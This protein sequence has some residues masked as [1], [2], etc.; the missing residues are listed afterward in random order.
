[1]TVENLPHWSILPNWR[2]PITERLE[3]QSAVL[4]G[5]AGAEQRL[6]LRWSPRRSFEALITPVG[7]VRT[8]FDLAVGRVGVDPW[9]LPVWHD[10]TF[11][12]APLA[13]DETVLPIDTTDRE[14]AAGGFVMLWQDEFTTEVL[15]IASVGPS[16][17]TFVA[18]PARTWPAGSR[19]FPAVKARLYQQ[20]EMAR[21]AGR[22]ME[23]ALRF[24]VVGS[25]DVTAATLSPTYLTFPVLT[26]GPNE[27]ADITHAYVRLFDELD[28][29][30]GIPER[31]HT[32][33]VGFTMQR[34]TWWGV[35]RAEHAALRAYFY[36]LEGKVNP[37]W[38]PTFAE[39][40]YVLDP[41]TAAAA[42]LRVAKCGFTAY[43]GPREGRQ[44]I[45]IALK[46]GTFIHRRITGST[47]NLDG[48]EN[49]VLAS[50]V[51]QNIALA[52][53]ER[54]SFM[55]LSRLDTDNIEIVHHTDNQGLC[56]VSATFRSAPDIRVDTDWTPPPFLNTTQVPGA[57][58]D[59]VPGFTLISETKVA[60]Q[61]DGP[62]FLGGVNIYDQGDLFSLAGGAYA[63]TYMLGTDVIVRRVSGSDVV[64]SRT[65][66]IGVS[67]LTSATPF[68]FHG[69][70]L[71]DGRYVT[72]T[73]ETFTGTFGL[74]S[75]VS[76][77]TFDATGALVEG[78]VLIAGSGV[79]PDGG[80]CY[81]VTAGD[82]GTYYAALL[83]RE[84]G[85]DRVRIRKFDAEHAELDSTPNEVWAT[86]GTYETIR[87]NSLV[88]FGDTLAL[89][90]STDYPTGRTQR[91][92]LHFYGT[93]LAEIAVY[94]EVNDLSPPVGGYDKL[95]GIFAASDGRL[96]VVWQYL[97]NG[98]WDYGGVSQL[99]VRFFNQDGTPDGASALLHTYTD[100]DGFNDPDRY[101]YG[102]AISPSGTIVLEGEAMTYDGSNYASAP[103][104]WAY[105]FNGS[106]WS[107]TAS[108]SL[109]GAPSAGFWTWGGNVRRL[110]NGDWIALAYRNDGDLRAARLALTECP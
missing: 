53:I 21:R 34:H 76:A 54:V 35:G 7:P 78:P 50:A 49:I 107:E 38:L 42:S 1:M 24:E 17:I 72:L 6:G 57:C 15:E 84:G 74:G 109:W 19:I 2:S 96:G 26:T 61:Y 86:Y 94:V 77:R 100:I 14:F 11:L 23:N 95:V 45:Q 30:V 18:G 62:T 106:T 97:E 5:A 40:L 81:G 16:S 64:G 101:F 90:H 47:L 80:T 68:A 10:V 73:S 89:A 103:Y 65:S 102:A 75:A 70:T 82:S 52:D 85:T 55:S 60:E 58:G 31:L 91:L 105:G 59:C 87:R 92:T 83:R 13:E 20:P 33:D 37:T 4:S 28:N 63:F 110:D 22:A 36:A 69:A 98:E 48:T 44:D 66:T 108:L 32:T 51:G 39:D 27:A 25:N 46:D 71:S 104:V 29:E 56:E 43:G 93:D 3:W 79:F 67:G 99:R 8:L 88:R 12:A 41:L 9:Y